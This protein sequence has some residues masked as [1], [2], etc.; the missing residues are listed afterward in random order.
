[1]SQTLW[2]ASAPLWPVWTRAAQRAGGG[3]VQA[4]GDRRVVQAQ[5][6]QDLPGGDGIGHVDRAP[7]A[8]GGD[9]HTHIGGE[10]SSEGGRYRSV[11]HALRGVERVSLVPGSSYHP[12]QQWDTPQ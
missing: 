2:S 1:M 12:G 11:G 8:D 5:L 9:G 10:Q 7:C 6:A 4:C 3:V